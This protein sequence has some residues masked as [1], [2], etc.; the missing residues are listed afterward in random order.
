MKLSLTHSKVL[1]EVFNLEYRITGIVL[2]AGLRSYV[3]V[4]RESVTNV[5]PGI[6]EKVIL[7]H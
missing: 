1:A 6:A 7:S 3:V 2:A 4:I 5:L